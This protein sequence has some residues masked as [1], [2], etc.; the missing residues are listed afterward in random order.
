M[1]IEVFFEDWKLYEGW[2]REAKQLDEE[3]QAEAWFWVCCLTI[4]SSFTQ[5]KQPA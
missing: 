3:D 2:G 1:G 5:S 4:A